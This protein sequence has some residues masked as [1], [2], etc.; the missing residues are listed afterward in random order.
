MLPLL[1]ILFFIVLCA[2]GVLVYFLFIEIHWMLHFVCMELYKFKIIYVLS[3]MHNITLKLTS[4]G[5][6]M[7]SSI[8]RC[9]FES[10]KFDRFEYSRILIK[11]IQRNWSRTRFEKKSIVLRVVP[12]DWSIFSKIKIEREKESKQMEQR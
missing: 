4:S 7:H 6:T 9:V 12:W 11:N 1:L 8:L 3:M 2:V 5:Q 10:N